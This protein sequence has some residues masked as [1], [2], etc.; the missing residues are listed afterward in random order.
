MIEF[1]NVTKSFGSQVILNRINL[2]IFRGKVTA[3]IGKSGTG[4]TVLL[5]HMIGLLEPTSGDIFFEGKNMA[6][7]RPE[8]RQRARSK[9][10]YMFQN[11]ALFDSINIY[12]N[13]ALPLRETTR[14]NEKEIRRRVMDKLE[15]LEI[16]DIVE[17][18]PSEIS[19]GMKKRV[20]LA[21][22]LVVDP[23]IILI[24]EP[25]TGL[26]PI[27]RNAVHSMI[28]HMQR[29]FGFTAVIVSHD[30]PDV[31]YVSQRVAMLDKGEIIAD[32]LPEEIP[33]VDN[34]VVKEFI[35]GVENLKDELTGLH[36]KSQITQKF[37]INRAI[38]AE[39]FFSVIL[40]RIDGLD[41]I[42]ETLGFITGQ[43]VLKHLAAFI[44][45]FLRVSCE[46][47]RYSDNQ[48]LTIL[49]NIKK[50]MADLLLRKLGEALKNYPPLPPEGF[51]AMS[52]TISAGVA[53]SGDMTHIDHVVD[54]T[55][56]TMKVIGRFHLS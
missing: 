26:D 22:A 8:E 19:G 30:I 3:I 51:Q 43:K 13:V 37:T 39:S 34:S 44:E 29:K 15:K 45:S 9:F 49:P 40:F 21:R 14:L 55:E 33:F 38:P 24:D 41:K 28:S 7:L 50:M 23:E 53:E 56:K 46:H 5:K 35:K 10:S 16:T 47:S 6:K 32:C 36:T 18:Y 42:N 17:K 2:K 52:Y 4:K 11:G 27:R 1:N 48:I 25:T 54:E 31:F 20:G 12:D